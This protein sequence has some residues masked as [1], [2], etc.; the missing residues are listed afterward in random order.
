[1][2]RIVLR[3]PVSICCIE[4]KVG[5]YAWGTMHSLFLFFFVVKYSL[6]IVVAVLK[7]EQRCHHFHKMLCSWL[8]VLISRGVADGGRGRGGPDP[9]TFENCWKPWESDPHTFGHTN[10]LQLKYIFLNWILLTTQEIGSGPHPK[11]FSFWCGLP[12]LTVRLD[13]HSRK[14]VATPLLMSVWVVFGIKCKHGYVLSGI[15]HDN[16]AKGTFMLSKA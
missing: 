6:K 8:S 16:S 10:W 12:W 7:W 13:T 1:M 5:W 15:A 9:R 3:W 11:T 14:S 2:V 4:T